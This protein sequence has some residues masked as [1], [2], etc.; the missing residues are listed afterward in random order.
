MTVSRKTIPPKKKATRITVSLSEGDHTALAAVAERCNVSLSWVTRQ[1]ITE[2][3]AHHA[4][5]DT[6][7]PLEL[8]PKGKARHA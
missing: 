6:R 4:D 3:L 7:L 8:K 1:A 5:S 2:F